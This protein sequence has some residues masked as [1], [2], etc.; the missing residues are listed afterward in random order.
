[1][2]SERM[3]LLVEDDADV[4]DAVSLVLEDGGYR[5]QVAH[6]GR[7]AL[8]LVEQAMPGLILLDMRMPI[9]SGWEF[10]TAFRTTYGRAVPVVTITADCDAAARAAEIEADAYLS[11]PFD[12]WALLDLV[13]HHLPAGAACAGGSAGAL[14]PHARDA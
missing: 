12:V 2:Q 4:A 5:V 9:M 11:K 6:N 8:A 13:A 10:A 1:M 7:E 3:I 14:P